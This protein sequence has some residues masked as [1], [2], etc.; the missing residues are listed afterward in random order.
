MN[1]NLQFSNQHNVPGHDPQQP[2][3]QPGTVPGKD[4]PGQAPAVPG[5]PTRPGTPEPDRQD[6]PGEPGRMPQPDA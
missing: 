5:E 1:T 3:Q 4:A 2:W 6:R